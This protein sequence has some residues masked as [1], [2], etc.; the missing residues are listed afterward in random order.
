MKNNSNDKKKHHYIPKAYLNG[1]T[2]SGGKLWVYRKGAQNGA[3][4][5]SPNNV[6]FRNYYYSQPKEDGTRD[7]NTLEDLFGSYEAKWQPFVER[8]RNGECV[9][10]QLDYFFQ[11][12]TLQMSR[13]PATRD[14]I[15]H[16]LADS[17][18]EHAKQLGRL[19]KLPPKPKN[20]P[21][22]LD[23][24]VVSIDPHKSIHAMA[25]ISKGFGILLDQLGFAVVRNNT[26]SNFITS[27]NPVIWFDPSTPED[28]MRPHTVR[29][30]GPVFFYFPIAKDL[31]IIGSRAAKP[32]FSEHGLY[33]GQNATKSTVNTFNRL[34]ARFA[35]EAFFSTEDIYFDLS[36]EFSEQSPTI[37]T[38]CVIG[39]NDLQPMY[40]RV[41]GYPRKKP[42]WRGN[43]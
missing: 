7:N 3:F 42:K 5:Q 29:P 21:D 37:E 17:V 4:H 36:K 41:F 1:F 16:L 11:F 12:L 39:K 6:G 8:L 20:H 14:I 27:D 30:D 15:E 25:E 43:T 35:Y 33:T 2:D 18:K 13:T 32:H 10:N 23:H 28:Q 38:Y 34:V 9:N 40:R 22:I 19:G 31:A 26:G 24:I